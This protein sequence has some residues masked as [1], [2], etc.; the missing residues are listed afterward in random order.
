[1]VLARSLFAFGLLF[2][3]AYALAKPPFWKVF[4]ETY[5]INPNSAI[6]KAKCLTCHLPPAPPKRNPY[7]LQ[8]QAALEAAN[9]RMVT[10]EM[11]HSIEKQDADADGFNNIT[12]IR[13]DSL[14]GD[15]TSKPHDKRRAKH[16]KKRR[17]ARRRKAAL[18]EQPLYSSVALTLIPI[19]L[20]GVLGRRRANSIGPSEKHRRPA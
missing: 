18:N 1:V 13:A 20:M 9:A 19:S 12:E 6:G 3:A 8:V 16:V 7:G 5:H 4:V 14:P 11:L 15:K 2:V 10:P 17:A